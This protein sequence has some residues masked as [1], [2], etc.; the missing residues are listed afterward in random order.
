MYI[1]PLYFLVILPNSFVATLE[2]LGD[3][4]GV[5]ILQILWAPYFL[6]STFMYDYNISNHRHEENV[7]AIAIGRAWSGSRSRE[8]E[9]RIAGYRLYEKDAEKW[10]DLQLGTENKV[11]STEQKRVTKTI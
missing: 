4:L 3:I 2:C 9:R 10:E 1:Y 7:E 5:I 11:V 8:F 6:K